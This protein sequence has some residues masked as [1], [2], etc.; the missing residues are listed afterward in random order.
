MKQTCLACLLV[1]TG[2]ALIYLDTED[3]VTSNEWIC[4]CYSIIGAQLL[5]I[6]GCVDGA[7]HGTRHEVYNDVPVTERWDGMRY[8]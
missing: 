5:V 4:I 3:V 1:T 6:F 2:Y 8:I 7:M